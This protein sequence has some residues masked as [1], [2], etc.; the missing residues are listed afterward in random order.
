MDEW[1][2]DI[3]MDGGMVRWING[4]MVRWMN[5]GMVR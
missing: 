5:G 1:L 2:G 3:Q 4:M